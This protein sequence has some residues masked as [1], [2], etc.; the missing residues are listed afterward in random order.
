MSDTKDECLYLHAKKWK[1]GNRIGKGHFGAVYTIDT[2][3]DLVIKIS[4]LAQEDVYSPQIPL[5]TFSQRVLIQDKLAN[6]GYSIPVIDSWECEGEYGVVVM[7]KLKEDLKSYFGR[8]PKDQY[9]DIVSKIYTLI[10]GIHSHGIV[11]G[12]IKLENI[13]VDVDDKLY[14][15]DFDFAREMTE[16]LEE[17]DLAQLAQMT[18]VIIGMYDHY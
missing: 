16:E 10:F 15:I 1:P 14:L 13:M 17:R 6:L 2:N 11:H 4:R 3:G 7:K 18:K 9:M 12:D 8:I 5:S